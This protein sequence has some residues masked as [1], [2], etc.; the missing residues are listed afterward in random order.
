MRKQ[1]RIGGFTLVELLVVIGILALLT[2][3]L[4]P[5]FLSARR[6]AQQS[7]CVSNLRQL[8]GAS[9]LYAQDSDGFLPSYSSTV[10][11]LPSASANGLP[12]GGC[13]ADESA[14]LL[15]ALAPYLHSMSIWRCPVDAT[16]PDPAQ[17]AGCGKQTF[18]YTRLISYSYRAYRV[19]PQGLLPVRLDY[20]SS[21]LPSPS[22]RPLVGDRDTCP[23]DSS[24]AA[25]NHGGR[26]NRV[27][28]DGHAQSYGLNCTQFPLITETP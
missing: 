26:W 11:Q 12:E 9:T 7:A 27:F 14:L 22:L 2:A 28:M 3:I 15:T 13:V 20:Q 4:F 19:L 17:R 6:R 8:Y 1:H 10:I 5:V 18:P 25:Y 23:N 24:Y 21:R 16:L